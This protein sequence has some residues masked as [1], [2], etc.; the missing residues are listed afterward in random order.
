MPDDELLAAAGRGELESE[1][2][3]R[4]QVRR[5]LSDRGRIREFSESFGIQW[6]RLDQLYSA[7]PDPEMYKRFYSGPQGKSTLHSPMLTEAL[8]LVETVLIENR[9]I[10]DLVDPDFTWL[11][12]SLAGLYGLTDAYDVARRQAGEA[13]GNQGRLDA[14]EWYRVTLPDR[15]RGGV[16]TMAGPLTLTSL[17]HRTSPIKRGAWLL[18]TI[19][20]RPPLN[21]RSR[22][23]SKTGR[24]RTLIHR[25]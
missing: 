17:P 21:Q 1:E 10:I 11:N 15:S 14:N 12:S 22:L 20:H 4:K 16:L 18:E 5:M 3:L 23:F 19:L 13:T 9:S 6:L 2:G 8:L 7:K 24:P 25:R